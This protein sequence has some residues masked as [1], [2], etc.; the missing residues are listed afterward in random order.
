MP[1]VIKIRESRCCWRFADGFLIALSD[2]SDQD[3][4]L[5]EGHKGLG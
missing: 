2:A 1:E 3:K 4:D 5:G